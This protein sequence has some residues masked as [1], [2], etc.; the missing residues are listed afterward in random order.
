MKQIELRKTHT[1][2]STLSLPYLDIKIAHVEPIRRPLAHFSHE[3]IR[4]SEAP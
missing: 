4:S 1:L 3:D 2:L